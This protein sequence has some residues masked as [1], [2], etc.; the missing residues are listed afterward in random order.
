MQSVTLCEE[1]ILSKLKE[2]EI[3]V[4]HVTMW[5]LDLEV[6]LKKFV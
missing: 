5:N 2:L 4:T 3:I 1:A 6:N